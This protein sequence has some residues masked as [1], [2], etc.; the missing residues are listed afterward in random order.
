MEKNA[1]YIYKIDPNLKS[2]EKIVLTNEL[3]EFVGENYEQFTIENTFMKVSYK[4]D[5]TDEKEWYFLPPKLPKSFDADTENKI[6]FRGVCYL[7]GEVYRFENEKWK[8]MQLSK[9]Y[10]KYVNNYIEF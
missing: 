1:E 7:N 3:K 10:H 4:K 9:M 6:L 5:C 8:V 2:I